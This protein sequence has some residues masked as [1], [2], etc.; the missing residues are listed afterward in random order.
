MK[1]IL[2]EEY[3]FQCHKDLGN[4]KRFTRHDNIVHEE[5]SN[6]RINSFTS[7]LTIILRKLDTFL[8]LIP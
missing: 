3:Y 8:F 5:L 6:F 7:L 2:N 1:G 4:S